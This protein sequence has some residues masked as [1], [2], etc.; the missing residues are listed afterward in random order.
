M[1]TTT[2]TANWQENELPCSRNGK[3]GK[4]IDYS[5]CKPGEWVEVERG[6]HNPKLPEWSGHPK[7][8][9]QIGANIMETLKNRAA[10]RQIAQENYTATKNWAMLQ[11]NTTT[12]VQQKGS[13]LQ[14][15]ITHEIRD[16]AI[17]DAEDQLQSLRNQVKQ[18][19]DMN[20]D[21]Q[22][23]LKAIRQEEIHE[24]ES[25]LSKQQMKYLEAADKRKKERDEK[26]AR[27]EEE[28]QS[29][30]QREAQKRRKQSKAPTSNISQSLDGVVAQ[31]QR[32]LQTVVGP[33]AP[34]SETASAPQS[35]TA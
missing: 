9:F 4:I 12:I 30:D 26:R 1:S 6:G 20:V 18:Y 7:F 32:D 10:A 22:P 34:Q 35:E 29:E 15:H 13:K 19:S 11:K 5:G 23:K 21:K 24:S 3:L 14:N 16:I 28:K 27:N 17:I 2:T 31:L 33:S 8:K 25:I